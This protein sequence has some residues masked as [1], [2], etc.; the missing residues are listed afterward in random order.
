MPLILV[1]QPIPPGQRVEHGSGERNQFPTC[2]RC[3]RTSSD[4]N[5]V[6]LTERK[7][8]WQRELGRGHTRRDAIC[9]ECRLAM[10]GRY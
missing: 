1:P 3:L 10:R 8:H 4:R 6:M 5:P 7:S 9:Y 2:D